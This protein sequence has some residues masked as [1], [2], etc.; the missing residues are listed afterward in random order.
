MPSSKKPLLAENPNPATNH[1]DGSDR[2]TLFLVGAS[3]YPLD[4]ETQAPEEWYERDLSSDLDALAKAHCSLVRV[5]VS[6]RVLEPQ[7]AQYSESMF[8]RFLAVIGAIRE[9]KMAAIVC[10]FADDR[11]AELSDVT[12]GTRR[13][14]RT[15]QYLLQR[16]AALVTT[17]A[18][19]LKGESGVFG[20]QLGNEAFL[21]RFTSAEALGAWFDALREAIR[22]VDSARPVGLGADAET[23]F[24]ATGIDARDVIEHC[25]LCV[26]HASSAYRAYAAEG[27]LGTGPSTY[28]DAY[29]LRVAHRGRPVILDDVGTLTPSYSVAEEA[30]HVRTVL[31]SGLANRAG[32]ALVRRL[33]DMQTE[34]REPYFIDPF[35][36]LV[37]VADVDG[38]AKPAFREISEFVKTLS[39][40]DLRNYSLI[41]E[42]TAVLVPNERYKPLPSLASLYDPRSCLHS[43]ITA[44]RAHVPVTVLRETDEFTD[45]L[46]LVVPSAFD[47]LDATWER[48]AQFVQGGG[49]LLLSYG[50]GDAHPAIREIFGVESLGDDG[51][52]DTLS[53]RIAQPD[54]LGALQSFDV[55]FEVPNFAM[56]S[57]GG[58]TI[59][60]TDATGNPL[61]T[62]NQ[63]GQGKAVYIAIPLERAIAQGD[64]WATPAPV[65]E[66]AMEV[67]GAVARGAGCGA[68]LKCDDPD[69]EVALFQGDGEDILVL[70]NHSIRKLTAPIVTDRM[71]ASIASVRPGAP[72]VV[73]GR[74]FGVPLGPSA[75]AVLRVDYA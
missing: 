27:P 30:A 16:E 64:P 6:W 57:S 56:L 22:E 19:H 38:M 14:P 54:V 10:L 35:E 70:I 34:K 49:T 32:G 1:G 65:T 4:S 33:R 40:V 44:K 8:A 73:G 50:G 52:R 7:V 69:V 25:E 9:R 15:D 74:S 63:L 36:S 62:V 51:P 43:F 2:N 12:W 45:Q 28:L 41:A 61:L 72:A 75:V 21:S 23:L 47:L 29:L 60:A 17:L 55:R 5:F 31:W 46:V 13:D 53:C 66:F 20:W 42:R 48:L 37:G 58:A 26:S 68:P 24:Q 11:H 67:Y 18:T 39:R 71:V 59:V 3:L